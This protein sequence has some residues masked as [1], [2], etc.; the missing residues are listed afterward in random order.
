MEKDPFRGVVY[1]IVLC[2]HPTL[3]LY[4]LPFCYPYIFLHL[5]FFLLLVQTQ[6]YVCTGVV[7]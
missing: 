2:D 1:L 7:F 6:K 4:F 5:K 3:F